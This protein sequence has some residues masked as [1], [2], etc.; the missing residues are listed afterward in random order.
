MGAGT[1]AIRVDYEE[2]D[3][4][5]ITTRGHVLVSDQ[6][7]EDGGEDSA[8]TPTELF[9]SGLAGCVAFYAERFLRRNGLSTAG[10]R[11]TCTYRWASN[12]NRVGAID[13]EVTAPSLTAERREAFTKVIDHC[14]VHNTLRQPPE[15]RITVPASGGVA[16][17]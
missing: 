5:L 8:P 7:V 10:L 6:P 4:L 2:G 3:R 12:P 9:L 15:V 17:A 16:A 14:T 1:T 11:V 13:L